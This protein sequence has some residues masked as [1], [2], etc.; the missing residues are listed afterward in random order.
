MDAELTLQEAA[1]FLNV[2]PAFV[3]ALLDHGEIASRTVGTHPRIRRADLVAYKDRDDAR[4]KA[5]MDELTTEAEK[6]GLGY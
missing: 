3:V 4:R 2:S 1:D 5:V 6:L